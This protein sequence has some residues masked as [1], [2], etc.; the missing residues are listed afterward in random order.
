MVRDFDRRTP[1][2]I[3]LAENHDEVAEVLRRYA[4]NPVK[5][6]SPSSSSSES[7]G[8]KRK[9]K[10]KKRAFS[11]YDEED[12]ADYEERDATYEKS[13]ERDKATKHAYA[14]RSKRNQ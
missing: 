13:S 10:S 3:A 8:A 6:C 1:I 9:R 2:D 14:T 5:K 4:S 12:D 11:L 7:N